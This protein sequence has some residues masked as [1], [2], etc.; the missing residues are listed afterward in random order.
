MAEYEKV[1]GYKVKGHEK[2][3][4]DEN[5]AIAHCKLVEIDEAFERF[6][7][8]ITTSN[9]RTW[10]GNNK[11]IIIEFLQRDDDIKKEISKMPN[12]RILNNTESVEQGDY[13]FHPAQ[14]IW[15]AVPTTSIGNKIIDYDKRVDIIGRMI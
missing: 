5:D 8:I 14:E 1:N 13:W 10:L 11:N 2:I 7:H 9:A 4:A 3:F 12:I 6:G 15:E